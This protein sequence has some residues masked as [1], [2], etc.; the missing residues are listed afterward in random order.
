MRIGGVLV[1]ALPLCFSVF[2]LR[3]GGGKNQLM[4][5]PERFVEVDKKDFGIA[6]ESH[7]LFLKHKNIAI[8]TVEQLTVEFMAKA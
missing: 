5:F 3:R 8:E 7:G 2:I 1:N 6:Y 4:V